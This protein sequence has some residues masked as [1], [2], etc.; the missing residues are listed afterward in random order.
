MRIAVIIPVLNESLSIQSTLNP[1][2]FWRKRGHQ[3]ILVDAESTDDTVQKANGLVDKVLTSSKGRAVQMNMGAEQVDADIL[4]FLHADTV[5]DEAADQLILTALSTGHSWGR[6]NIAFNSGKPVF[7]IIAFMMNIRSCL[8]SIATGD[9][10]IF[11]EKELFE[12]VGRYPLQPIMEDIQL[13][14]SLKKHSRG[15]CLK[16]KVITSCR[17][18][19]QNGILK[20][21]ILMWFLRLAY[22]I[23]VPASKLKSWY[24]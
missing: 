20:T 13:S 5:I 12:Q 6:F 21:I 3:I 8:S 23:G 7:K 1:L 15:F 24:R 10:A 16:Q 2:Q 4:L 9:Q 19:Q 11:V 14:I 17:R 18:W 22:F